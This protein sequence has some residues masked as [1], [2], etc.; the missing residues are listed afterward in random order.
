MLI[1]KHIKNF[2]VSEFPEIH[3][4]IEYSELQGTHKDHQNKLY[5]QGWLL[6]ELSGCLNISLLNCYLDKLIK[7]G[8]LL[9]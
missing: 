1:K 8:V 4:I 3:R 6:G 5:L 2:C 7:N 9:F